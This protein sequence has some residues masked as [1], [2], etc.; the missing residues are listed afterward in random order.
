MVKNF[1]INNIK[2]IINCEIHGEHPKCGPIKGLESDSGYTY[3][4]SCFIEED[5]DYLNCGFQEVSYPKLNAALI[6][7]TSFLWDNPSINS[8]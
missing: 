7:N 5:I 3:S 6:D 4:P 8:L 1:K 2:L